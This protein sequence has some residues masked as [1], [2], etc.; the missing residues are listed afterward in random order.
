MPKADCYE[1][2]RCGYTNQWKRNMSRHFYELKNPCSDRKGLVL[3]DEI[4]EIVLKNHHYNINTV[5]AVTTIGPSQITYNNNNNTTFVNGLETLTKLKHYLAFNKTSTIDIN[6]FVEAQHLSTVTRLENDEFKTPHLINTEKFLMLIDDMVRT[7]QQ[8]HEEMNVIYDDMLD[9]IK[10]YCDDEWESYMIDSGMKR[11]IQILRTNYLDTY[12]CYMYRKLFA[13]KH[14]NGYQL[15]NVRIKLEEYYKFLCIFDH[16]PYIY[17]N[18]IDYV[19]DNYK[20]EDPDEFRDFGMKKYEQIKKDLPKTEIAH[21]KKTVLDIIKRNN[22]VNLKRL[23]ETILEL[24]NIDEDFKNN[25]IKKG[26]GTST[27]NSKTV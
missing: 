21:T 25:I 3:T 2:P 27:W 26:F 12:E 11:I 15:N 5:S 24:I 19:I 10:I 7:D 20:T 9:R 23:N 8:K 18:P 14:I 16:Y 6:D 13:D 4:K 22:K 1:C 17:D